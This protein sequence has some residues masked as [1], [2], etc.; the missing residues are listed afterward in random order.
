MRHM[1]RVFSASPWR[2]KLVRVLAVQLAFVLAAIA[3][4]ALGG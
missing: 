1:S 2:I 3:M 4:A